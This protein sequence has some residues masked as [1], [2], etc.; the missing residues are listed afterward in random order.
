MKEGDVTTQLSLQIARVEEV[1]DKVVDA[2]L[3]VHDG[4]GEAEALE[5]PQDVTDMA[6]KLK[7]AL[8][9]R[10]EETHIALAAVGWTLKEEVE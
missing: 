2:T 5:L 10:T 9:K 4:E 8:T 7:T 6:F 1:L 3:A